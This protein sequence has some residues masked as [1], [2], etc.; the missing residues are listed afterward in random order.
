MKNSEICGLHSRLQRCSTCDFFLWAYVKGLVYVP[1]LPA[2]LEKLEQRITTSPQT[3]THDMGLCEG[4]MCMSPLFL[5]TL[6]NLSRESLHHCTLLP[7]T[8]DYVKGLV[9]VPPLPANLEELK[10]IITTSPQT[11]TNDML[12]HV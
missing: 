12:Q 7:M 1:P 10:Q 11:A 9:Y 2:N 6:M 8:W 3:V 4:T 5:Q